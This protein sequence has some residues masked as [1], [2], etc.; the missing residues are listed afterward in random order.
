M[1]S[2]IASFHLYVPTP[3]EFG[4]GVAAQVGSRAAA[5]GIRHALLV[6]DAGLA[7]SA[8]GAA[9]GAALE[10]AGVAVTRYAEVLPDPTAASIT[11]AVAAYRAAGADGMVALGGGSA[12]DTAKALGVLA[13]AG[14]DDVTP[15]AFG[16][17]QR[18]Q[19]MP[20]LICLPTTA[21]TGA[22][23]TFVAIV[24]HAGQKKLLRDPLLAPALALVD[25]ALT[26]TLPPRLTAAT[27]MDALAHSLEALTSN[28]ANPICDALALDAI[29]RIG[30]WLPHVLAH[31]ADLAARSELSLAALTAGMAF[32]NAR[33][34]LGHAVGHSLGTA[35]HLAHGFACTMCMPAILAYLR[36]VCTS[37]LA[38]AAAVLGD[39]DAASAVARLMRE[40]GAPRMGE[41]LDVDEDD[42]PRLVALVETEERLINLSCR[43]PDAPAWAEIFAESL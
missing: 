35:F 33:V 2:E 30:R 6:I 41:L 15:F 20:P 39:D 36:P 17:P 34:H 13:V 27:A 12:M 32:L 25:P 28:Q 5:L 24:T 16:G 10:A 3:V 19:G 31:G 22:E 7:D 8:A 40:S 42:I 11:A 23:V 1:M 14:G 37:Q 21:G 43:R 18:I 9:A 38:R 4:V 29:G 26:L